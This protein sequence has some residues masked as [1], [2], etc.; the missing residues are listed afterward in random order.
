MKRG[1]PA[2]VA[3]FLIVSGCASAVRIEYPHAGMETALQAARPEPSFTVGEK[4]T[5]VIAWKGIPVGRATAAVEELT[6]FKEY[7]VYKIAVT[8]RT[9][10]FLSKLFRVEDRFTSYVDRD[11]LTSRH[12]E[13][14]QR[15]GR[16]KKDLVVDYDFEKGIAFYKNLRDNTVKTCP[17]EKD[18]QDPVSA[19]Y[20]FRAM[21]QKLGDELR[22][23]VNLN[24]ENYEIIGCIEKKRVITIPVL[25]TFEAFL[26]KP[27][28][29][30]G[31][32]R[33]KRA[34]AWGYVSADERRLG[35]FGVIKVLEIP[36]V[37]E[38]TG[39]LEKLEYIKPRR[40]EKG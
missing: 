19:A 30:L 4:A 16:Y 13:T 21:P 1:T 17:I 29:K 10:E 12:F 38:I 9:N 15:E 34:K 35:L 8:A 31:G 20:Y 5:F 39:T 11:T 25:G 6:K 26:I 2:L 28:V 23:V 7:N 32:K 27:Y 22:M 24:E 40:L 14:I 18:V 3:I 36:W 37:G 33:Q